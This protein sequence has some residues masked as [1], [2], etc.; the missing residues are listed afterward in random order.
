M[1]TVALFY[2]LEGVKPAKDSSCSTQGGKPSRGKAKKAEAPAPEAPTKSRS[3]LYDDIEV[4]V[5]VKACTDPPLHVAVAFKR[6][7][8]EI[9]HSIRA[10]HATDPAHIDPR[11]PNGFVPIQVAPFA[12]NLTAVKTLVLLSKRADRGVVEGNLRSPSSV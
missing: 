9:E 12:G 7:P 1:P 11:D 4:V 8:T 5:D 2:R 10:A 3:H 6:D